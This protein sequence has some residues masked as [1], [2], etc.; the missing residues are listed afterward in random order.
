MA[1]EESSGGMPSLSL[2]EGAYEV[3]CRPGD[4]A[5]STVALRVVWASGADAEEPTNVVLTVF[6][7]PD[8]WN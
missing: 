7:A 2:Q 5:A 1:N 6:E 3:E 8:Q 4:G